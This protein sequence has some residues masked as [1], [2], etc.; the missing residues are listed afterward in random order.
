MRRF[1]RPAPQPCPRRN[2]RRRLLPSNRAAALVGR[3]RRLGADA[4]FAGDHPRSFQ[5]SVG[6][7]LVEHEPDRVGER[8]ARREACAVPHAGASGR[9]RVGLPGDPAGRV[10]GDDDLRRAGIGRAVDVLARDLV[11]A[12]KVPG[13]CAHDVYQQ[14]S[15]G[16]AEGRSSWRFPRVARLR[17]RDAQ[18]P[19]QG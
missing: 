17:P 1:M 14:K 2:I 10:A 4:R 16:A 7:D 6:L 18:P 5:R 13:R 15:G 9:C 19:E 11:L 8:I 12:G 3:R